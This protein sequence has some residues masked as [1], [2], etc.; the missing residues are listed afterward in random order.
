M[1]CENLQSPQPPTLEQ[2]P[3]GVNAPKGSTL[4]TIKN[5]ASGKGLSDAMNNAGDLVGNNLKNIGQSLSPSALIGK[6]GQAIEG[7][8]DT[9]GSRVTAAIDGV[10]SLK[11]RLK[12]FDPN[13]TLEGGAG[14]PDSIRM[15]LKARLTGA[16]EFAGL[17]ATISSDKCG[18]NY[19][20]QAGQVNKGINNDT[21]SAVKQLSNKDK[22]RMVSDPEFRAKKRQEIEQQVKQ[23]ATDR[24]TA[25]ASIED[26]DAKTTQETLQSPITETVITSPGTCY[27][28][29]V[30]RWLESAV[31]HTY[32]TYYYK[33]QSTGRSSDF[34]ELHWLGINSN[35]I[36]NAY[37][38]I[39][40]VG[41][42]Y[43]DTLKTKYWFQTVWDDSPCGAHTSSADVTAETDIEGSTSQALSEIINERYLWG[44]ASNTKTV[45]LVSYKGT[46]PFT[47]GSVYDTFFKRFTMSKPIIRDLSSV[48]V[49]DT[50]WVNQYPD[51]LNNFKRVIEHAKDEIVSNNYNWKLDAIANAI[52]LGNEQ[53]VASLE[54][55]LDDENAFV[56][57][58]GSNAAPT[59]TVGAIIRFDWS[60]PKVTSVEHL[61][62]T[63]GDYLD[64]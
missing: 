50:M 38:T 11:D 6:I 29:I 22:R 59:D 58:W 52:V 28:F 5:L 9:I 30:N 18:Q 36:T 49:L 15:S 56:I 60:A 8:V 62:G 33:H 46:Y 24:A 35:N 26:K 25:A 21:A 44:D 10:G 61:S 32:D 14:N 4:D 51:A 39:K 13:A 34:A 64:W 41:H 42:E 48:G 19:V 2:M 1:S 40:S 16:G 31:I 54:T 17:Q 53:L 23:S 57:Y 27:N 3:K 20:K 63:L 7:V 12:S 43:I 55:V 37:E 47:H 45:S